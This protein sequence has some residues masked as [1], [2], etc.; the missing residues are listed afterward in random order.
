MENGFINQDPFSHTRNDTAWI[1]HSWGAQIIL[2]GTYQVA[3]DAGLALYTALLAAAGMGFVWAA[4]KGNAYVRGFVVIL[5]S[6]T[7]SVFWSARPQMLT[8]TLSAITL[9][10]LWE[11]LERDQDKTWWLV[12]LLWLWG[13]LH[14]GFSIGFILIGGVVAGGVVE[15]LIRLETAPSWVQ[16][17]KLVIVGVLG[18]AAIV[19]NPLRIPNVA[20][21]LPNNRP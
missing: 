9:Y 2:W 11:L 20:R 3:G 17:R 19:V 7:A 4:G 13:N 8:F 10:I 16:L 1:N 15:R 5:T 12:P 18:L 21:P 6:A 14:A